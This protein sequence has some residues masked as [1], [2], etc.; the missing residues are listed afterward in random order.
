LTIIVPALN[1]EIAIEAM[2]N[3]LIPVARSELNTFE[4]ILVND[5]SADRTPELANSLAQQ[6]LEV[7]V[8]HHPQ[9]QGL[10]FT[11]REGITQAR[12]DHLI[13]LPGDNAYNAESL[14]TVFRAMD[15]ADAVISYR[16]NQSHSRPIHR[17]FI[18]WL[19]SFSM[20][21]L[22]RQR[23]TDYHSAVI[24]PTELMRSVT[25]RS[26]NYVYQLEAVVKLLRQHPTYVQV[27]VVLNPD[28]PGGS[29][30]LRLK[31]LMDLLTAL[32]DL[33]REA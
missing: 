10:G 23:V 30:S 19:F 3:S 21:L 13:L 32:R 29:R 5:G 20:G 12:C 2:I 24:Y 7:R 16:T 33:M 25:L 28:K 14:R 26:S 11:F 9:R 6:Y 1:E 15:Q 22:F 4:I 18:S 31:T 17:A 27:P 8:I